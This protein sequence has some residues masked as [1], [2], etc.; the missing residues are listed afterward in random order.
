MSEAF[1]S[2]FAALVGRPNVGKSTLLNALVGRKVAIMSDKP[3]TTRNRIL[4]V[5]HRPDAQVVFL[6]TPGI[7]KPIHRLGAHLNR[8]AEG[9]LPTVDLVLFV[10]DGTAPP[11]DGD[12]YIADI[13]RRSGKPTVLVVNKQDRIPRDRLYA[14]LDAY[15]ALA[16]DG[17]WQWL[18]IVP[19]SAVTGQHLEDLVAIICRHLP[20][21]PRYYPDDMVT[22]QPEREIIRELIREQVLHLTREEV[23][24]SAAVAIEEISTRPGGTVYVRAEIFVEREGQKGILV[25]KRGAMIKEVGRRARQEIEGLLGSPIYL[26]LFIKVKEDWRNREGM[27]RQFGYVE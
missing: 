16:G 18:D 19:T 12:R 17:D 10:V 23:P 21:G 22:D 4:G 5:L 6:D 15:K 27:L 2:G 14:V 20:A 1:V 24:H 3:Q 25:G 9:A 11:G 8:V 26:D 7:H 13:V